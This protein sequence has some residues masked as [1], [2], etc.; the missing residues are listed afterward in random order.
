MNASIGNNI[1]RPVKTSKTL[2]TTMPSESDRLKTALL[3]TMFQNI[4]KNTPII[5]KKLAA[6]YDVI[7]QV[8]VLNNTS[9][10]YKIDPI[11]NKA[12]LTLAEKFVQNAMQV[13]NGG[14]KDLAV[15]MLE[16]MVI[17]ELF[18]IIY[19]AKY[20][21]KT[22]TDS[23]ILELSSNNATRQYLQRFYKNATGIELLLEQYNKVD[24]DITA[25]N[26]PY[27]GRAKGTDEERTNA[28]KII[29]LMLP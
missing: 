13:Y 24:K 14:G 10:A 19:R 15:A 22:G 2:A 4:S 27:Q 12:T 25:G 8:G 23:Q 28:R 20:G 11:N 18:G 5:N 6:P 9:G 26:A 16:G 21:V 29:Q 7:I 3:T 1:T 17:N